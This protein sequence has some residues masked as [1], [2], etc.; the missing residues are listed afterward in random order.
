MST[1]VPTFEQIHHGGVLLALIVRAEFQAPGAHFFTPGHLSQQL[2]HMQHPAGHV[3]AAH[4]H[5][6]IAREVMQTQEV[7]IL[8]R[9]RLRIDFYDEQGDYLESRELEAGDVVLLASGGHGFEV[10]ED[11]EMI[12]VKQGPYAGDADKVLLPRAGGR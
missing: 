8:R 6:A 9:G 5:N 11:V 10:L 2:A 12:E 7:L 4:R 3:I 1:P